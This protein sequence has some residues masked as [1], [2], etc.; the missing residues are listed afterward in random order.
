MTDLQ[1]LNRSILFKQAGGKTIFQPRIDCW[2]DDRAYRGEALPAG[3]EGMSRKQ[4]YEA[5]GVSAR[6]YEFN[7]CL[8]R[9]FPEEVKQHSRRLD[10]RHV[11]YIIETPLG[12]VNTIYAS[13]T[14]NAG[15]MPA[16][17]WIE[18]EK[19][20][21]IWSY[22]DEVAEYRFN[23]DTYH[24]LQKE[25]G[26]L[27]IP[28]MFLPRPNL[29]HMFIEACG[30]EN[31]Y[32]LQADS[33]DELDAYFAARS[34]GHDKMLKVVAECP[35]ECINY[36]DNLHCKILPPYLFEKYILPEYQKRGEVLHKAGKFLHSHWDGDVAGFLPYA[37]TCFL[38]GIEAITPT[39]QGDV[40]VEQVK[41][42]LGDGV[43][44]IDGLA[45]VLFSDVYPL[46]QLKHQVEQLLHLFEGQ[47][48]LGISD[49][50]PSD[51]NLDRILVVRDMVEEFNAKR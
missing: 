16:K 20:L 46:D 49:E 14:S 2:Y 23:M 42:A 12:T 33:P 36:G 7:A 27:G 24:R 9:Y 5:L 48:V 44:L 15:Q 45:A 43:F 51:G 3:Y 4:L 32:Y 17:W 28:T 8:E 11:E 39:P 29:Q 37:K 35:I 22:L 1:N 41:E 34:R 10:D 6:L 26:H 47:L 31:T 30:V 13:N 21:A 19:D 50:F 40:T 25:L 18:D 38:D